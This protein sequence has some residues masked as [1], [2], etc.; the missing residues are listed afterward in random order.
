MANK[1]VKKV[2]RCVEMFTDEV[3]IVT[4]G[5]NGH[6]KFLMKKSENGD[7]GQ[8]VVDDSGELVPS[9]D[10][11]QEEKISAQES[12]S[13]GYG[14]EI[15]GK[16]SNLG[17]PSGEPSTER[18][19]GDPVNLKYPLAHDDAKS[20]DPA[21]TKSAIAQFRQNYK[22]YGDE[23]SQKRVYERI[24]RAALSAKID[25]SYDPKN[26]VDQLLPGDLKSRLK[27]EDDGADGTGTAPNDAEP[28]AT[29]NGNEPENDDAW[30]DD[31]SKSIEPVDENWIDNAQSVLD[32]ANGSQEPTGINNGAGDDKPEVKKPV[33][34]SDEP[35]ESKPSLDD[36]QKS[37]EAKDTQITSMEKT[38]I[39]L[40]AEV[41]RL[42]N[43]IGSS[44]SMHPGT[45]DA[46]NSPEPDDVVN[47]SMD[48]S[49]PLE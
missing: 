42:S 16:G 26:P 9:N 15:L 34:K 24:V 23:L 13:K 11:S 14:I 3:S 37:S 21:R 35:A 2:K 6:K 28:N 30:L 22:S 40:K 5:A 19:Y 8:V 18:L 38:I 7:I 31:I 41:S 39:G 1:K 32:S 44:N 20:S 36:V 47:S 4:S 46:R 27:K 49:P 12:R 43:N 33:A 29:D 25:V 48:L 10:A 45:S 17:Y